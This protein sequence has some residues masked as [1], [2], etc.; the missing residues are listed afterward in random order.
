M[1]RSSTNR[2]GFSLVELLVVIGI[3]A[4]LIAILLPALR[5][6]RSSA[7]S[8]ACRSNLRQAGIALSIYS[9]HNR[10]V[11]YPLGE[12]NL[13]LGGLTPRKER[14]TTLVFKEWNP[15]VLLCPVSVEPVEEHSYVI[16]FQITDNGVTKQASRVNGRPATEVVF[17]GEK[18]DSLIDYYARENDYTVVVQEYKHGIGHGSSALFLDGHVDAAPIKI[19]E[20]QT[21]PWGVTPAAPR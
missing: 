5:K 9:T 10:G 17:M 7:Q 18:Y 4:V 19:P 11:L 8:I 12:N 1:G 20:G 2:R 13:P 16:N 14:W 21:N 6:A 3:I 15:K